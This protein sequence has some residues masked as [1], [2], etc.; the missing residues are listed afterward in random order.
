MKKKSN[1]NIF[2][3]V[4]GVLLATVFVSG[5]TMFSGI[6]GRTYSKVPNYDLMVRD[7]K[8]GDAAICI[9][10]ME[11]FPEDEYY[12]MVSYGNRWFGS[13]AEGYLIQSKSE[14]RRFE[15]KCYPVEED[16]SELEPNM[17]LLGF[18]VELSETETVKNDFWVKQFFLDLDGYRYWVRFESREGI[19]ED[20]QPKLEKIAVSILSN[21]PT[22]T[23]EP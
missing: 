9:P 20:V 10:D 7:V 18:P 21:G 14:T 6:G 3:I 4:M 16:D 11:A 5:I 8:S 19:V 17:E 22:P 13:D 12:Y 2:G 23:G 1:R 15:V